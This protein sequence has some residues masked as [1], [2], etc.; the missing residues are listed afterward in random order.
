MSPQKNGDARCEAEGGGSCLH[1]AGGEPA[2]GVPGLDDRR[3]TVR[4][5]CTRPDDALLREAMKVVAAERRRFGYRRIHIM[6]GRQGVVM[7]QKKLRRLYREE[8]LQA[9]AR[10]PQTGTGHAPAHACLIGPMR[11]GA[12][13]FFPTRSRTVVASGCSLHSPFGVVP[14]PLQQLKLAHI[15]TPGVPPSLIVV[16]GRRPL[17]L[18]VE[19]ARDLVL[20]RIETVRVMVGLVAVNALGNLDAQF[21]G[22]PGAA[23]DP[24][25]VGCQ[26]PQSDAEVSPSLSARQITPGI[27]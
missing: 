24:Q 18:I 8:K 17:A 7:N 16:S 3:S 26:F 21:V 14:R 1:G 5:K 6:P 11:A 23:A 15:L 19:H 12:S 10:R 2:S 13:I 9:P 20:R 22:L 27:V 25:D 4:Y